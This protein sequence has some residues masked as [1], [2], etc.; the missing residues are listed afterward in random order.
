M[1]ETLLVWLNLMAY[2]S[3]N[4]AGDCRELVVDGVRKCTSES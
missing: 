4:P 2:A 3:E 1:V